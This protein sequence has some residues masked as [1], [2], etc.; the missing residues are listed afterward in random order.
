MKTLIIAAGRG[1]RLDNLTKEIPKA[2]IPL[3]GLSLTERVILTAKEAGIREY[4][5]VVGYLG[6]KIKA[7][8]GNGDRF[9]VRIDYIEN[10]EW[11]KAMVFLS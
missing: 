2:L 7:V 10:G 3:L 9:R 6:E 8:L 1:S 4:V 11:Q 5:I